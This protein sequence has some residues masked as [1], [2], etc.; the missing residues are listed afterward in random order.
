MLK[1]KKKKNTACDNSSFSHV[2]SHLLSFK[3]EIRFSGMQDCN[4]VPFTGE[5]REET[6]RDTRAAGGGRKV[7]G[8]KEERKGKEKGKA[9]WHGRKVSLV[10]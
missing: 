5:L 9:V 6:C 4:V 7:S 8:W 2:N 3:K 10:L 1:K